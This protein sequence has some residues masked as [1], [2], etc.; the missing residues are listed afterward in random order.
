MDQGR[1]MTKEDLL[2][3]CIEADAHGWDHIRL[4]QPLPKSGLRGQR[5][6]T[7]FG[8]CEIVAEY[9]DTVSYAVPIQ[10]VLDWIEKDYGKWQKAQNK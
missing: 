1:Q 3:L 2:D 7:M 8:L 4:H 5:V 10:K 6:R 9:E